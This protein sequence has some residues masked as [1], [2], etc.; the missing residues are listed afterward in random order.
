VS[1]ASAQGKQ[2]FDLVNNTGISITEVYITPH[3]ATD[4]GESVFDAEQPLKNGE[5]TTIMFSR[6]EKAKLWDLYVVDTVGNHFQWDNLNLLEIS[7]VTLTRKCVV[8]FTTK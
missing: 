8:S 2:D 1:S 7:E 3:S 6:K 4:W 5:T